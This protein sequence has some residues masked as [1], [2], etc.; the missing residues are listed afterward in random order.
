MNTVPSVPSVTGVTGCDETF[1]V[2]VVAHESRSNPSQ[3]PIGRRRARANKRS[4]VPL[5]E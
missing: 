2:A 5:R 1:A 4:I 3:P